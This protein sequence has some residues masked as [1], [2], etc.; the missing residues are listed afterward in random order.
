MPETQKTTFYNIL[1]SVNIR[2]INKEAYIKQ[3]K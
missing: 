2:Q 1:I 3:A